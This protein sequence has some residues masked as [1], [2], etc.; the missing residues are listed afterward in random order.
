LAACYVFV[1]LLCVVTDS[2]IL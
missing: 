1:V 2:W